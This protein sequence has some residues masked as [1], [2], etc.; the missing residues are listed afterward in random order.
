MVR[1]KAP[2]EKKVHVEGVVSFVDQAGGRYALSARG[3]SLLIAPAAGAPTTPSTTSTPAAVLPAVGDRLRLELALPNPGASAAGSRLTEL[4]RSDEGRWRSPLELAG[5]ISAI[6]TTIRT[7]TI[8]AD[9]QGLSNAA[10]GM[11][12]PANIDLSKLSLKEAVVAH[13]TVS[14]NGTYALAGAA[15]DSG[16]S[17]ADNLDFAVGDF[18][19][20]HTA[21]RAA[22]VSRRASLALWPG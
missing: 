17:A 19:R 9:G 20:R 12:V 13:A 8:S 10:I 21:S 16:V 14:A 7:V 6:D 1:T 18:Q 15:A 4:Q 2:L 3:V 11:T 22:R 5:V